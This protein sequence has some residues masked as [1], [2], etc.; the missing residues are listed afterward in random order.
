MLL[1]LQSPLYSFFHS[2]CQLHLARISGRCKGKYPSEDE[3]FGSERFL[4]HCHQDL[5]FVLFE[6]APTTYHCMNS[7]RDDELKLYAPRF[8]TKLCALLE[9]KYLKKY[10]VEFSSSH[11]S[12]ERHW[13]LRC[14]SVK[15]KAVVH[16]IIP[17]MGIKE[18]EKQGGNCRFFVWKCR[19]R[20]RCFAF[21][22]LESRVALYRCLN[23]QDQLNSS[24]FF[25]KCVCI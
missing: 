24:S 18:T 9:S 19:G 11:T 13:F 5:N 6:S 23:F 7:M 25:W 16:T 20:W 14:M 2:S 17:K 10:T 1:S 3:A 22:K 21:R 12:L 8:S 15:S 4:N